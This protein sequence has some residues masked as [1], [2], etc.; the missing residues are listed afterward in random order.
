MKVTSSVV[1]NDGNAL[2]AAACAGIGLAYVLEELAAPFLRD[3][4]LVEVLRNWSP[5]FAGYHAYYS[6]RRHPPP[7]VRLFIDLLR[8]EI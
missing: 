7:A 3:G 6:N 5:R 8:Q 4:R 2:V 1:V